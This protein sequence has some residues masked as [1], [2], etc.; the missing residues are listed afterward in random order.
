MMCR[1]VPYERLLQN[2][3]ILCEKHHGFWDASMRFLTVERSDEQ[4]NE[5][6]LSLEECSCDKATNNL[7]KS[8]H[9]VS[10]DM[11]QQP[12]CDY[13]SLIELFITILHTGVQAAKANDKLHKVDYNL[14]KAVRAGKASPP[15]PTKPQD[16][17]PYGADASMTAMIAWVPISPKPVVI[18]LLASIMEICKKQVIHSVV[19]SPVLSHYAVGIAEI[20]VL[21]WMVMQETGP[22]RGN[23]TP[24]KL[25]AD[26]K[27]CAVF[28]H[29]LVSFSDK[30]S[31]IGFF[32][33]DEDFNAERAATLAN[34]TF[35]F[36]PDIVAAADPLTLE[37]IPAADDVT[38][39]INV[40]TIFCGLIHRYFN[41]PPNEKKYSRRVVQSSKAI[42]NGE[43]SPFVRT[44][45][46]YIS[47]SQN[48][49]C[50][51]PGCLETFS[52]QGRKFNKCAGCS[53]V[54]FCSKECQV[55]RLLFHG[56][57][58][59]DITQVEA[60]NHEQA[61]HK[62]VCKHLR[63]V[64]DATHL[65]TSPKEDDYVQFT[66][67]MLNVPELQDSLNAIMVHMQS[68]I[69]I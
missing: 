62:A 30:T 6:K 57:V 50:F 69:D 45:Q 31:V 11:L 8:L 1:L 60:W 19:S 36:L 24:T 5:L 54:P 59:P 27:R 7:T 61:P 22:G 13:V 23:Y 44:F 35:K 18:G 33:R 38:Y 29:N 49:C 55:R 3:D 17:L 66:V 56:V 4:R 40:Y 64:A 47:F 48:Q 46:A 39:I 53:R 32:S 68:L 67:S 51:A 12:A 20:P 2:I 41:L 65:P 28:F 43:A 52:G 37:G 25:L 34:T 26:L 9:D 42:M 21:T 14:E 58:E 63:R 10:E 15:W 16:I